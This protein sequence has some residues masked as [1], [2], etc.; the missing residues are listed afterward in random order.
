MATWLDSQPTT[1]IRNALGP[2]TD[3]RE[4]DEQHFDLWLALVD[5]HLEQLNLQRRLGEWDWRSGYED[6][7][8]PGPLRLLHGPRA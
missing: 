6:G 1:I 5:L 8:S 4:S 3:N 7:W 2:D